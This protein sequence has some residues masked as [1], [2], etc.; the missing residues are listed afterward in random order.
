MTNK[1]THV[2]VILDETDYRCINCDVRHTPSRNNQE[3]SYVKKPKNKEA[4]ASFN[5]CTRYK[6]AGPQKE[7][8]PMANV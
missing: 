7:N 2:W 4:S 3:C 5:Q 8:A 6:K 1:N